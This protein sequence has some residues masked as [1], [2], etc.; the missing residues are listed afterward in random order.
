MRL[1]KL[2]HLI[3][4]PRNGRYAILVGDAEKG[5]YKVAIPGDS[6]IFSLKSN[7]INFLPELKGYTMSENIVTL[8]RHQIDIVDAWKNIYIDP[9]S[10]Y[11]MGSSLGI[12]E[13]EIGIARHKIPDQLLFGVTTSSNTIE[14]GFINLDETRELSKVVCEKVLRRCWDDNDMPYTSSDPSSEKN[15]GSCNHFYAARSTPMPDDVGID[16]KRAALLLQAAQERQESQH[17]QKMLEAQTK[18][19]RLEVYERR[20]SERQERLVKFHTGRAQRL[21]EHLALNPDDFVPGMLPIGFSLAADETQEQ[22]EERMEMKARAAA[23]RN[24]LNKQL[25]DK[26]QRSS[27]F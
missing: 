19:P 6:A 26:H 3:A 21:R 24:S 25:H 22:K 8:K 10:V 16:Q 27:G 15:I 18:A 7:N 23:A 2:Q 1:V 14:F 5:R 17:K 12:K 11:S 4:L 20:Q 13:G 9:G